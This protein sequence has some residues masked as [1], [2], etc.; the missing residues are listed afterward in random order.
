MPQEIS[1]FWFRRDLRLDD[2]AGLYHALRSEA[3]VL[4]LFVFD[5]NILDE[6]EEKDDRRV[7]FIYQALEQMQKKLEKKGSTLHVLHTTPIEAFRQLIEKYN[8]KAVYTNTDYEPYATERD[9]EVQ[10]LLKKK[11]I[12]FQSFKDQVIFEKNE[13]TK[14]NGS[15]YTIFTPYSRKWQERLSDFFLSS[16]PT[17]KYHSHFL[18]HAPLQIPTPEEMGF[19]TT[20]VHVPSKLDEDVARNYDKTRDIPAIHGTTRLSV[21]LRFGTIS[22]RQL[23]TDAQRLNGVLLKE[24]IWRDFYQMIMWHFPQVVTESFK[25]EYDNIRWRNNEKEFELWC[26]GK[27]GYPIVDAGMRELNKTGY[28][29]NRVRMI[30]ASF[31][32][33]HLLIDWRWGEAYFGRK[34]LDYD[35]APNN[36]GWQWAAGCGCDAVPYFRIF[37]PYLQAKKFDPDGEY[38]GQWVPEIDTP[39]YPQPIVDHVFARERCLKVYKQALQKAR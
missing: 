30:T 19:L 37:N 18:K 29:H 15:P 10:Q 28:M 39:E 2:N 14:E 5:R 33:K 20:R 32:T 36:G 24:L 1:I 12:A 22:I 7:T 35:L 4:P 11:G 21:H 13:V 34:L 8:V 3:P 9:N 23:A 27:T 31:L 17:R 16:Y 38:V 25:K 6:L 26:E